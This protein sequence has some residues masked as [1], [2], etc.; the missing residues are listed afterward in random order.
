MRSGFTAPA[1]RR[2]PKPP[3]PFLLRGFPAAA[4]RLRWVVED[5]YPDVAHVHNTWF[6]MS[7]SVVAKLKAAGVPVVVTL[8][9]YRAI[10]SAATLFR[11]GAPCTDCARSNVGHA[12]RGNS[13]SS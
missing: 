7:P 13:I 12:Y 2:D 6:A 8:H 9:N 4:R 10:R 5:L 3:S 11:D 1:T